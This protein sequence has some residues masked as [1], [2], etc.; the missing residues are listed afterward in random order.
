MAKQNRSSM[1]IEEVVKSYYDTKEK[2]D[3]VSKKFDAIKKDFY[4]KMDGEFKENQTKLEVEY[5]AEAYEVTRIQKSNLEFDIGKLERSLDKETLKQVVV[6]HYAIT[7][8]ERFVK[9]LKSIGADPAKV[10]EFLTVT[11]DV[12]TSAIDRLAELGKIDA[13]VVE[14]AATVTK[15]KPYY[16]V[17]KL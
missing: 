8:Y 14:K 17:K 16:K 6:R 5:F 12:D 7:D 13:S 3:T 9:Y 11:K 1:S 4:S 15:G 2:F 10:K